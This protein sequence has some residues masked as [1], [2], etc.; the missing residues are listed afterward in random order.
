MRRRDFVKATAVSVMT[1]PLAA[2]A[3]QGERA[4][5]IGVMMQFTASDPEGQ[6]RSAAFTQRLRELG[7]ADGRNAHIDFRWPGGD[8]E[9]IQIF[10]KELVNLGPDVIVAGGAPAAA[11]A[12]QATS[13]IPTVF[14]SVSDPVG[15][16]LVESLAKP[17]GNVT[18]FTSF[19]FS[20][21]GKWLEILQEIAPSARR[22]ALVFNPGTITV[23]SLYLNA[24]EAFAP[25]FNVK[26]TTNPIHD[27]TEIERAMISLELEGNSSLIFLPDQF[28]SSHRKSI[29]DLAARHRLPAIYSF[30][31]FARD[32]GLVSYGVDTTDMFRQAAVYVDKILQGTNPRDL[33]V[34]Q[35][36]KF[37][38]IINL[39]TAKALDLTVPQSLLATADEVI[40]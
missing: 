20:M 26:I 32:G 22:A 27:D 9:Q 23:T 12:K 37:E 29:I 21:C 6:R 3:Q 40:E 35:P 10:A 34:Q 30:S 7:W 11:A 5:R 17:G 13:K 15:Q 18:G 31:Y 14:L 16:S 2:R 25:T 38:L 1:W 33:P 39:K 19:E 28:T 36:I 24:L 4:R 8:I